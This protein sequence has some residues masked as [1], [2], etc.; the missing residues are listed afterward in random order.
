MRDETRKCELN[1]YKLSRVNRANDFYMFIYYTER[2]KE[3]SKKERRGRE[4]ERRKQRMGVNE[5][6]RVRERKSERERVEDLE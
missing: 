3:R 1:K 2:M 5:R 6:N 4:R